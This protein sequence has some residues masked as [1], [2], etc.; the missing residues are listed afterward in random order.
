MFSLSLQSFQSVLWAG[1][2]SAIECPATSDSEWRLNL[3]A[4][5]FGLKQSHMGK[6]NGI[7]RRQIKTFLSSLCVS[8]KKDRTQKRVD[9]FLSPLVTLLL[10]LGLATVLPFSSAPKR[11]TVA[12]FQKKKSLKTSSSSFSFL[13]LV[14][15]GTR[16]SPT[17]KQEKRASVCC[18]RF[19][20]PVVI[21]HWHFLAP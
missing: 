10:L 11:V 8:L 13:S 7:E 9:I 4:I 18:H 19:T 15:F 6:N 3:A 5:R 12:S 1:Q 2:S 21:E 16:L 17:D 20:A 14:V